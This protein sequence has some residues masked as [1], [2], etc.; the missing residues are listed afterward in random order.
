VVVITVGPLS[1][2]I[3]RLS[4][5]T[6]SRTIDV[7]YKLEAI[8]TPILVTNRRIGNKEAASDNGG[9]VAKLGIGRRKPI[10]ERR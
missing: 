9:K 1:V 2:V 3:R 10:M 7:G 6:I 8:S 4:I 5:L